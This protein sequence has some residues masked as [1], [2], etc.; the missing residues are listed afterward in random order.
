MSIRALFNTI[1]NERF[2]NSYKSYPYKKL[3]NKLINNFSHNF[4]FPLFIQVQTSN[5]CNLKC[6]MCPTYGDYNVS[7]L[8]NLRKDDPE[9]KFLDPA[10][11]E[12]ILKQISSFNK[13]LARK[14]VKLKPQLYDEPLLNPNIVDYIKQAKQ[15]G[16]K[17]MYFDTNGTLLTG[18]LCEELVSA[19]LSTI[20]VSLDAASESTY[21]ELRRNDKF[22][23]VCEMIKYLTKYRNRVKSKMTIGVS[24]VETSSNKHEI[25]EFVDTWFPIVDFVRVNNAF[26]SNGDIKSFF[27]PYEEDRLLCKIPWRIMTILLN[28]DVIKCMFDY[29]YDDIIGNIFEK[30][31][32]DI[33]KSEKYMDYRKMHIMGRFDEID[34]CKNCDCWLRKGVLNINRSKEQTIIDSYQERTFMHTNWRQSVGLY[35][36]KYVLS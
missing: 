6:K 32:L 4:P 12:T 31:I 1:T 20:T 11:F 7:S 9:P 25:D 23:H 27:I 28:G 21:M 14:V 10:V 30:H 3:E 18:K 8:S 36:S 13:G 29:N 26:Y 33:W 2:I 22:K 17:N 5:R 15:Y 24:F 19:G 35:L 34:S 16:I